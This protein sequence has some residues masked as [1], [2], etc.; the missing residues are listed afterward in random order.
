MTTRR[1]I[2]QEIERLEVDREQAILTERAEYER[3]LEAEKEAEAEELRRQ[4]EATRRRTAELERRRQEDIANDLAW[5]A[6]V[7]EG[8]FV[9]A[10]N[11]LFKSWNLCQS[12]LNE[13]RQGGFCDQCQHGYQNEHWIRGLVHK[14][15][16]G[17][18]RL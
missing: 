3:Q 18:K 5:P 16:A 9:E 8:C 13:Q 15:R 17:F 14:E 11:P 7:R 4:E 2:E 6:K 10:L 12:F 1:Q